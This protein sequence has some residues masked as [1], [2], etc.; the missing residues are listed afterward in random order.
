MASPPATERLRVST[1]SAVIAVAMLGVTLA[2]LRLV[3]ASTR[4]IGWLAAAV[5]IAGLLHPLVAILSRRLPRWLALLLVVACTL[6]VVGF[7]AYRVVDDISNEMKS[8]EESVPAAAKRLESS[9]RYGELAREF[10]LSERASDFV[11]EVPNRLRGG[12]ATEALRSAATRGV[13]FLATGVLAL[14]FLLSGPRIVRGALGQIGDEGRRAR[15]EEVASQAYR[16]TVRYSAGTLLMAAAAGLFGFVVARMADVRGAAPLGLWVGLWDVVPLIG[17]FLGALPIVLL[18]LVGSTAKAVSV[19]SAFVLYQTFEYVVLQR[20]VERR[21]LHLGPF[22][23]LA[24]GLAGI[25]LYGIGG[26]LLALVVL[27]L[28]IAVADETLPR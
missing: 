4:V 21:S 10:N 18:A 3:S 28:L 13:A 15:V 26:G 25:E 11:E 19:A 5:T 27:C 8:L 12:S 7:V 14:F 20:R 2:L 9:E 17:A 16:K 1:R 24:G 22:L 23:S 6:A